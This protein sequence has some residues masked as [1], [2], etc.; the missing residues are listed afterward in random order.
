MRKLSQEFSFI[1]HTWSF[2]FIFVYSSV[3]CALSIANWNFFL[4]SQVRKDEN[5]RKNLNRSSQSAGRSKAVSGLY[6]VLQGVDPLDGFDVREPRSAAQLPHG[7]GH[8]LRHLLH[9]LSVLL[10]QHLRRA[11]HHHVPG[12]RSKRT[13]RSRTW[14][15]S[16]IQFL[17]RFSEYFRKLEHFLGHF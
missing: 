12:T 8:L 13:H 17:R 16:G 14:Q 5:V 15:E 3:N 11:H 10:H 6:A 4:I 2:V 1:T 9:R 7:D